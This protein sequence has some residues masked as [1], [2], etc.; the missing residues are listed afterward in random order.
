MSTWGKSRPR[1]ICSRPL[2]LAHNNK[3][4]VGLVT[5]AR[6]GAVLCAAHPAVK[7]RRPAPPPS[8]PAPPLASR[9]QASRRAAP[10]RARCSLRASRVLPTTLK[11][12]TSLTSKN[13][14]S[15]HTCQLAPA[16][17]AVIC[18]SA[19]TSV[20]LGPSAS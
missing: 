13:H 15:A 12:V 18:P 16:L 9:C 20:C 1:P 17:P 4:P 6:P 10:R 3:T 19:R 7:A 11:L 5:P 14:L 8:P 2:A